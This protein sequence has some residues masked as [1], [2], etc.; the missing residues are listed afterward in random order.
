MPYALQMADICPICTLWH[1]DIICA[2]WLDLYWLSNLVKIKDKSILKGSDDGVMP[3]E[4]SYFWALSIVQCFSLK[5]TFR[6]LALHSR[7]HTFPP[8]FTWR[9][10]QRQLPKRCLNIGR[11][12]KSNSKILRNQRQTLR[13]IYLY[14]LTSKYIIFRS[15]YFRYEKNRH[16]T[17]KFSLKIEKLA[18]VLKNRAYG[19]KTGHLA[20]LL[21]DYIASHGGEDVL[22]SFPGCDAVWTW[23]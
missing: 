21:I 11:W 3:F 7:Y 15:G 23:R 10:R 1:V 14:F 9:R 20:T 2:L 8:F 22:S 18:L 4:E 6:K 19:P 16:P 12:I 5:T 17:K 13:N